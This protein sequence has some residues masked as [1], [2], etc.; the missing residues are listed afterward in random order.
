MFW[1]ISMFQSYF[2]P[3]LYFDLNF[4]L[5]ICKNANE[6][7]LS[8]YNLTF[9]CCASPSF[10]ASAYLSSIMNTEPKEGSI[11]I[12]QVHL[13]PRCP[14]NILADW[15]FGLFTIV[16]LVPSAQRSA[17]TRAHI[18]RICKCPQGKSDISAQ[19]WSLP[20]HFRFVC[21]ELDPAGPRY[22]VNSLIFLSFCLAFM[23]KTDLN[24]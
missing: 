20:L 1:A 23:G 13:L 12:F 21:P 3:V 19:V 10:W 18:C 11:L 9:P 6:F 15:L 16:P 8:L 24:N 2:F 7:N 17:N 5:H 4:L 22:L 14:K